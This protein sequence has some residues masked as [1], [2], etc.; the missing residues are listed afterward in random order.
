[1]AGGRSQTMS[2]FFLPPARDAT[3]ASGAKG[4][5]VRGRPLTSH[6]FAPA[7]AYVRTVVSATGEWTAAAGPPPPT[8][9]HPLPL[10]R[11]ARRRGG[12]GD[13]VAPVWA[14]R[15][16]C[17]G[18]P[19]G[20]H[21]RLWPPR[22]LAHRLAVAGAGGSHR[23]VAAATA[24]LVATTHAVTAAAVVLAAATNA[25]ARTLTIHRLLAPARIVQTARQV[26]GI[27]AAGL[28]WCA[29][30]RGSSWWLATSKIAS[31]AVA[32]RRSN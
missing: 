29:V 25:A 26:A 31:L 24:M 1:M 17:Q 16:R 18:R 32:A 9:P 14:R 20:K 15:R 5:V 8:L 3:T 10:L 2:F 30:E 12:A 28:S 22:P 21:G 23:Y 27:A 19:Q 4:K 11:P 6:F 7:G 13:R